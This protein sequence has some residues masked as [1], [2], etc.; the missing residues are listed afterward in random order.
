[1]FV[2]RHSC[3]VSGP[4]LV[5]CWGSDTHAPG[6]VL[7]WKRA[8]SS[9]LRVHPQSPPRSPLQSRSPQSPL[10]SPL[11]SRSP[12]SPP[13]SP[14]QSRSPQ[15]PPRS[16]LQSRSPQSPLRSPL[17]SRSPQSPPRS[18][19]QS[20]SPQSPLRS[21]LQSRSPQ[22]P[23]RSPLQSRSPQSPLRSP[24]ILYEPQFRKP[25]HTVMFNTRY[26]INNK[27]GTKLSYLNQYEKHVRSKVVW[28]YY[29]KMCNVMDYVTNYN[30]LSC[31]SW[32]Q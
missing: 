6:L 2:S 18:P 16:P 12:Q 32:S 20:R 1:M 27:Y 22:S 15:S 8:V 5:S 13:L 23:L 28:L 26:Y 10:R 4:V 9:L 7:L 24:Q 21:P 14:L 19:L 30:F 17:Q 29:L 31:L 11:Q 25:L 3:L